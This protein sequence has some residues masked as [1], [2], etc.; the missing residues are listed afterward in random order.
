MQMLRACLL[1]V[2]LALAQDSATA[3][4]KTSIKVPSVIIVA[5]EHDTN[6][7]LTSAT[8]GVPFD[9]DGDGVPEQVAWTPPNARLAFLAIDSDGDGRI[10][11]GR[12]LIGSLTLP[13]APNG[14][15]ALRELAV[16]TNG[17][18]VRGSVSSDDPLFT[19]LL[20]WTDTNHN[21]LSEQGELRPAGEFVSDVG[22]GYQAGRYQRTDK[23][24]NVYRFRGWVHVRTAP[25]RNRVNSAAENDARTR[26]VFEVRLKPLK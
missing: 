20:L 14:F 24:G 16:G 22:L 15:A 7:A 18:K 21:G 23:N 13:G 25:G 10:T 8:D 26:D 4:P 3:N 11:S 6:Y 12:E 5:T 1:L 19:R 2:A 17:G 9:L